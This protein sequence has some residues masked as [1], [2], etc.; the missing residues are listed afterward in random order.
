M[1]TEKDQHRESSMLPSKAQT[2]ILVTSAVT[3]SD[4]SDG[5]RIHDQEDDCMET[6]PNSKRAKGQMW[7]QYRGKRQT[8]I[9]DEYQAILL[10]KPSDE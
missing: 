1:T 3:A 5:K 8:R 7:L 6:S 9:G 10:P 2:E 4:D